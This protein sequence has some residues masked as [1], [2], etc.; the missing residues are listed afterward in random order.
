MTAAAGGGDDGHGPRAPVAVAGA[1]ALAACHL[2]DQ[3]EELAVVLADL[4]DPSNPRRCSASA[5]TLAAVEL[6]AVAL[7]T[8]AARDGAAPEDVVAGIADSYAGLVGRESP[9]ALACYAAAMSAG[10]RADLECR[11]VER[12]VALHGEVATAVAAA[13]VLA[14]AWR[15]QARDEGCPPERIAQRVAVAGAA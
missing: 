11:L 10:G 8:V 7:A 6:S 2:R 14:A 9:S 1:A 13:F 12:C 15:Y 5:V 4:V 3:H